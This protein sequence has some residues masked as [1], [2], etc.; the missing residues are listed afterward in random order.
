MCLQKKIG[1]DGAQL[2]DLAHDKQGTGGACEHSTQELRG[3]SRPAVEVSASQKRLCSMEFSH[4]LSS[5]EFSHLLALY[6]SVT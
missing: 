6:S 1:C 3:I 5:M 4:L 2:I